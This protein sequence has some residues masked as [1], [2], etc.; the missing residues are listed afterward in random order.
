MNT[1]R[2]FLRTAAVGAA[3]AAILPQRLTSA[4]EPV[5]SRPV[6]LGNPVSRQH[7]NLFN[8]DSCVFFYNPEKWQPEDFH[9]QEVDGKPASVGGPFKAKAIH[10]FVE[11]LATSGVDTFLVNANASRAWYPS[12]VIPTILDGYRRG[13]REYFRG[14]AICQGITEKGEEEK[15]IDRIMAF[16][17]LY[18]DLLDAKVDWLA[19]AAAACRE[20]KVSPWVSIRM[21]DFHGHR[22]IEGSFF[23]A[24]LLKNPAMRLS[25]S[26]YSPT[27]RD[28]SYRT[29][30]NFEKAEVRAFMFAQIK[31]VV[32][33]YDYEGLELDW[34]RNPLCCEPNASAQTVAMMSD[35]LR[36]VRALTQQRAKKTGRPYPLGLRVPGAL[37][38]LKS[39]GLDVVTLCRDGTLD[40]VSPSGFWCTSWEMP[41][42]D[43]RRAL[44]DDVAIY[45]VIEDGANV[46]TTRSPEHNV[47]QRVRYISSSREALHANAAGKHALGIDGIE[48]FNFYCT[49]QARVPG[50]ISDYTT[51][52]D[53][54]RAEFL[55]GKPK[56]YSFST[57]GNAVI[58]PPFEV[59]PQ[60]PVVLLAG[61]SHPFRIPMM[62]EPT[63]QKL[64]LVV[65]VVLKAD[66][67]FAEMPVSFNRCWPVIEHTATDRLLFPCGS[68]THHALENRGYDFRFPISLVSQ[69]WNQVVVENGGAQPITVACIELAI[70]PIASS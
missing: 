20:N 65:Q 13:D 49:D 40:F 21:N 36:E 34:L 16:M 35:W 30:L 57:W 58:H 61:S 39:I 15:F 19:E 5:G 25:R 52:H 6:T 41:H 8:G 23:N 33:D 9:L 29:A 70:R 18:Q 68:L 11:N 54:H 45:G 4:N 48:W 63:D 12:K 32:E 27:M 28:P 67:S 38:M 17:N 55:L 60:L 64:E 22:N 31:E 46:L 56:H 47:T 51:L 2:A 42:D 24:P 7:R 1:R 53:V 69:G 62:A 3:T 37:E 50:V 43:L 14:H 26:A 44:G 66:E 59:P 10:R